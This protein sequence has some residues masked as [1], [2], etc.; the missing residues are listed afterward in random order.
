ML[1]HFKDLRYYAIPALPKDWIAPTWLSVQLC[2]FSGGLYFEFSQ[3]KYL[4]D[5]LGFEGDKIMEESQEDY[6]EEEFQMIDGVPDVNDNAKTQKS[7]GLTSRPLTFLQEWLSVRRKG[8][9]FAHSPMGYVCQ[10]KPL[11]ESHPFFNK[12]EPGVNTKSIQPDRR[13][14]S[15]SKG[16]SMDN[17]SDD[18]NNDDWA[19]M[20]D[21]DKGVQIEDDNDSD[22]YSTAKGSDSFLTDSGE[23]L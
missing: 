22:D 23:E 2:V 5:F 9:D 15:T 8:Q 13:G 3:Y 17:T 16:F 11:N 1:F 7:V 12:N 14:V 19:D 6:L 20:I 4:C 18:E 21:D 10:G